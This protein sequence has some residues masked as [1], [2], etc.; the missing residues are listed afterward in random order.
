[1]FDSASERAHMS[2]MMACVLECSCKCLPHSHSKRSTTTGGRVCYSPTHTHK[3]AHE[4]CGHIH[5]VA[6]LMCV[7]WVANICRT[8][9]SSRINKSRRQHQP[10][11]HILCTPHLYIYIYK[12][13]EC[14]LPAVIIIC[15]DDCVLRRLVCIY[16]QYY[17]WWEICPWG[18]CTE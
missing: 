17:I 11:Q 4:L 1:M 12:G 13:K 3:R 10:S 5:V 16:I 7:H 8:C 6:V 14:T 18:F 15:F 2:D 9:A